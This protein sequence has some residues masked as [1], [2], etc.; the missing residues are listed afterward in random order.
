MRDLEY[1]EILKAEAGK[2]RG[3]KNVAREKNIQAKNDPWVISE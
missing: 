3:K 1:S 2:L